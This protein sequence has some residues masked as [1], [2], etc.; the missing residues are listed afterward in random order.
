M[1]TPSAVHTPTRRPRWQTAAWVG[2]LILG[3]FYVFGAASD[4]ASDAGTGIP[5]DHQNTFASIAG[6]DWQAAQHGTPGATA[7]I[8]MLERGYAIHE[9]T[10]AVLFLIILAIPFRHRRRW[11]W[12]AC[13]TPM[14]ANLGYS[15]TFGAHDTTIFYRSLIALIGLP[16]LLLV[17][18]PAFFARRSDRH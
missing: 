18:L 7:Y 14:I 1:N 17:H 10:F 16:I 9:L 4:L 3:G 15:L 2:L 6:T 13:W 8:T 11:A 12:W 5:T